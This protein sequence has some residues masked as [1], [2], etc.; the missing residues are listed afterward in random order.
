MIG[1][2]APNGPPVPMAMAADSGFAMAVRGA[3]LLRRGEHRLHRLGDAV[4]A[5]DR[6]PP[7]EQRHDRASGHGGQDDERPD[8]ERRVV[9]ERRAPLMEEEEVR[10]DRDETDQH[11]RRAARDEPDADCEAAQEQKTTG[12]VTRHASLIYRDTM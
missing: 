10:E 12:W 9:R 11:P 3:T 7:R 1:P 8:V 5:D 6:R 2:S 4:A